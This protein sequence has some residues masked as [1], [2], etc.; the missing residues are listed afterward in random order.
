[1]YNVLPLSEVG[2]GIELMKSGEGIE[3]VLNI[4][5]TEGIE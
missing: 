1:M 3:I 4:G 2:R 5:R